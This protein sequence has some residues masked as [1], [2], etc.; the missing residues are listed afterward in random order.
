MSDWLGNGRTRRGNCRPFDKARSFVR[1][2]RLKSAS[3]WRA[4]CG[5][6]KKPNDIP[7]NPQRVYADAGWNDWGDWL[8][9]PPRQWMAALQ[10]GSR[11]RGTVEVQK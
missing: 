8:G 7:S 6:G 5:S 11:F 2:L 3:D 10:R 4:Y 9:T 1:G